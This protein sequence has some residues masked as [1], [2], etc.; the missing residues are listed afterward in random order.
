MKLADLVPIILTCVLIFG[1]ISGII[2]STRHYNKNNVAH[3]QSL[4]SRRQ[5]PSNR[6]Q[7]VFHHSGTQKSHC[8]TPKVTIPQSIRQYVRQNGMPQP[9]LTLRQKQNWIAIT[10]A[11]A[12]W[13]AAQVECALIR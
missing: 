9:Q 10:S 4:L 8:H 11:K 7:P 12:V 2:F 5:P 1:I 6:R 3:G 13:F